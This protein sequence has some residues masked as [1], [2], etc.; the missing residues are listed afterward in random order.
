MDLVTIL[1]LTAAAMT[2]VAFLP[3]AIKTI[4]TKHTQDLS[5]R[6]YVILTTGIVLWF[7]YGVLKEDLPIIVAN[8]ITF[9]FTA[10]ILF[11]IIKN[12]GK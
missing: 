9:V 3:Q 4:R 7:V 8:A 5:L 6:M 12:S 2:T 11:F 1:G 10:T